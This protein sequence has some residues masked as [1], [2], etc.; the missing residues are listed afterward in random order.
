MAGTKLL[1]EQLGRA[2]QPCPNDPE[3]IFY[4][5]AKPG[6]TDRF[7]ITDLKYSASVNP[8]AINTEHSASFR[9]VFGMPAAFNDTN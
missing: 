7:L 4:L 9:R 2:M 5:P 3:M 6:Q 1:P 8:F